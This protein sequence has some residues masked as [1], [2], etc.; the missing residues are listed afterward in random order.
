[1]AIDIG[2]AKKRLLEKQVELQQE[3]QAATEAAIPPGD[4]LQA[5]DGVTDTEEQAVDVEEV[6]LEE[7]ILTNE[8]SLLEQVQ[9]A[10]MRIENGTYG[11]CTNLGEP[12]PEK[13]L[14]ALPWAALCISCEEKREAQAAE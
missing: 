7:D 14:E 3:I 5:S 1:M 2:K 8:R 12:I 13:R 11:I 4:P 6:E 10:L 9:Q